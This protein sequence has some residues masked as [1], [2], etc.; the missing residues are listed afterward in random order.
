ME[1]D[2]K[3]CNVEVN[4]CFDEYKNTIFKILSLT[5]IHQKS[6][7]E[8]NTSNNHDNKKKHIKSKS[9]HSDN[10][11]NKCSSNASNAITSNNYDNDNNNSSNN[12]SNNCNNVNNVNNNNNCNNKTFYYHDGKI[13]IIYILNKH[14][15]YS[16]KYFNLLFNN[17]ENI[18]LI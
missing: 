13:C 9:N 7:S 10:K 3:L 2:L 4:S 6:K 11:E 12:S 8:S 18:L 15:Y 17:K 1:N 16:F 14:H 5:E